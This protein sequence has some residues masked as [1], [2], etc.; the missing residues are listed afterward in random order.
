MR[1]NLKID[2]SILLDTSK[3][4]HYLE[5]GYD[6]KE[7]YTIEP[8]KLLCEL[9]E[10]KELPIIKALEGDKNAVVCDIW[11]CRAFGIEHKRILRDKSKNRVRNY[12]TVPLK[13]EYDAIEEYCRDFANNNSLE[14]RQVQSMIWAGI[15]REQGVTN[16]VSWSILLNKKRGMFSFI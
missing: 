1:L 11:M 3:F 10:F 14:A 12:F 16:N 8:E 6:H 4:E 5:K 9:Q 7:W 13:K 2:M 15:K